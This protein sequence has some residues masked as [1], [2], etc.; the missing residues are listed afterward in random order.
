MIVSAALS[1]VSNAYSS[2]QAKKKA[3]QAAARKFAEDVANLRDRT[4]TLVSSESP[5]A[6]VYGAPARVGGAIVAVLDSGPMAQFK[7]IVMVFASHECEAIDEIFIDGTSV[8]RPNGFGWTDGP[9][10]QMPP[11]FTGWPSEGPAVNVQFHTS[12]SGVDTADA[13][14]RW[15]VDQSFPGFNLWTEQ[16]KLSGCTYAVVTLNLLFER[17]QGGIPEITARLRGKKVYDP[18]TGQTAYSRNPALCL[19]DFLRS[20]TGYLAAQ[21]QIDENALIAAANACDQEVYGAVDAVNYGNS[22][23][24]YVCDGMFR[25]DQD[26]ESTRQQL[27]DSMAG[28]SLESGGVWRI[29]AGAWSTPVLNL[30]D[31]DMLAPTAVA[32]TANPGASRFNGMRGTYVNAARNGVSEDFTPYQNPTFRALDAKDKFTDMALS[33]TTS[34]VRCH[35]IAR[36]VVEQSRGGFVLRI[37]PKMLAWHLQPGDRIV[38][39]SALY[40]FA[41]KTFRVQD[42]TYAR[43]APL[44]LLV[45]EDVPAY[46]DLA[47]E[48]Q[49]DAAPNT[50]LPSPFI[51]PQQPNDLSVNSGPEHMVQQDGS[52]VIRAKVSW[53]KSTEASVLRGGA[54]RLQWRLVQ[55]NEPWQTIDLPG[56]SVDTYLL[57]L[58]VG[59]IYQV[60]ARFMTAYAV[61]SWTMVEHV[62]VGKAQPPGSVTGLQLTVELTGV[63][64]RWQEPTG[65]DLLDLNV[66]ELRIGAEWETAADVFSGR[67][68]VA[69][70]GWLQA[71]IVKVWASHNDTTGR[72]SAP[73]S[74]A[75]QILP[76]AQPVV[77]GEARRD[78]VELQWPECRTTQPLHGYEVRVGNIFSEAVVLTVVNALGYA[79]TQAT[80][81]NYLYWISAID[82]AGN[83]GAP[84]YKVLTTLPGID[85]AIDE[86]TEGLDEAIANLMDIGSRQT[87]ALLIEA[88]QRG[89]SISRVER[90]ITEGDEQLAQEIELVVARAVGYTRANLLFNGGFEFDLKDWTGNVAGWVTADSEFG[91]VAVLAAPPNLAGRI[92]SKA[93][94]A[95]VNAWYA[96][97]GD[98]RFT[99]ASGA[100]RFGIEYRD[101]VDT[102]LRVDL[103]PQFAQ[104]EFSNDAA[105]RIQNAL[106]SQAPAG[107][108]TARAFFEWAGFVAPGVISVRYVKAEAGR[109]PATGY[110]AESSDVGTVAAVQT[111][112]T[113]RITAVE[114]EATARQTLAVRVNG[115]EG[116]IA[117][118]ANVRAEETGALKLRYGVRLT[119]NGK[120]SGFIMNNDGQQSD[121]VVLA[122]KFAWA[123]EGADGKVKYPVVFGSIDGVASFGFAGNMF[124]DGTLKARMIDAEQIYGTH[125]RGDEITGEKIRA[126][127]IS[128]RE[129]N[130]GLG[131]N[132]LV[133]S[134]FVDR[135]VASGT[136]KIPTGWVGDINL[137]GDSYEFLAMPEYFP[138]YTPTGLQGLDMHHPGGAWEPGFMLIQA[139]FPAEAAKR[140]ECS[141]Y[142][143]AVR[144]RIV[145][146]ILWFDGI[147]VALGSSSDL[148]IE[149]NNDRA[150]GRTLSQFKRIG[151]FGTAPPD[152]AKGLMRLIKYAT[153]ADSHAFLVAPMAAEASV[154]QTVFSNYAP[155]GIGTQITPYGIRTPSISAL[156]ADLGDITAGRITI[157]GGSGGNW[158]YMRSAGKWRD[159]NWGWALAQH[160]SGAMFVD[161]S[162]NGCG[163]VMDYVPGGQA[164]F[165]LWG[166][167]FRLNNNKLTISQID[168]IDTLQVQGGAVSTSLVASG[169]GSATLGV[170]VPT[171]QVHRIVATAFHTGGYRIGVSNMVCYLTDAVPEASLAVENSMASMPASTTPALTMI[172]TFDRGPGNHTISA[173]NDKNARVVLS[174][175]I[176]KRP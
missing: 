96:V 27:E 58:S 132:L 20:E 103:G 123:T 162:L 116:A 9:E 36:V 173:S 142:S 128:A 141:V 170:S 86:L 134:T 54:V 112:T 174:L 122:D 47:D 66:T 98:S 118:E 152:A 60:R 137:N 171:G 41:N 78:Q 157:N 109:L 57:G 81:G 69:N 46:Y 172:S 107:T 74:T 106:E 113:A 12:P 153:D 3:R 43:N 42:W 93:F 127:T 133:N 5:W 131:S 80:P 2:S 97:T 146:E 115:V 114:A 7:H 79:H 92:T 88:M 166:P 136:V 1:L 32:Q 77:T 65:L 4:A 169:N 13:F 25:S 126:G 168:V 23:A 145:A 68:T 99:S 147:G 143:G 125:I 72:W 167:G 159:A 31:D 26:R 75:I 163:L 39:T 138:E 40:G 21:D 56:E 51:A 50:N 52:M 95:G 121:F 100:C 84:G 34:H 120:A 67:T 90:L 83:R 6:T 150:G 160:P 161:F 33:F 19:A 14:I 76:P 61:S 104:H 91:R 70:I 105:R 85:E 17:F 82:T 15:N 18:R 176:Q 158:G 24:L 129:I 8:G 144:S 35:Q 45:I 165:D 164:A 111:E 38:L 29:Q 89:T 55:T 102:V 59:G 154:Y 175:S 155:S 151:C 156:S 64:A 73:I 16:H 140:Y 49:A 37:H 124:L 30:T 101:A 119:A 48:V 108:A 149:N 130:V 148:A 63:F 22:R 87:D 28:F 53:A 44:S 94:K 139:E 10:F 62:V 135:V 117:T 110:T 71:G 11:L